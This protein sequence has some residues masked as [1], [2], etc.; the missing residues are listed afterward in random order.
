MLHERILA[1]VTDDVASMKNYCE[2]KTVF[3][4][5]TLFTTKVIDNIW[6]Q[7]YINTDVRVCGQLD[8]KVPGWVAYP[9]AMDSVDFDVPSQEELYLMFHCCLLYTSRCV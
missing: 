9:S 5:Y 4:K 8:M 2:F 1:C 7:P 3:Q 6:F